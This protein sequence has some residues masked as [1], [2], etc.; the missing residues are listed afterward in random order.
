MSE[1]AMS[2]GSSLFSCDVKGARD[3]EPRDMS[4][5]DRYLQE[6]NALWGLGPKYFITIGRDPPPRLSLQKA[7]ERVEANGSEDDAVVAA[8]QDGGLITITREKQAFQAGAR[9]ADWWHIERQRWAS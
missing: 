2:H 6:S 7:V 8:Y 9:P 1:F 3:P 5:L 4:A